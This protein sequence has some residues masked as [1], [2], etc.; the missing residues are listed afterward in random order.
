MGDHWG[1]FLASSPF[2]A[3]HKTFPICWTLAD[4]SHQTVKA[5]APAGMA[6]DRHRFELPPGQIPLGLSDH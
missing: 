6:L 4:I 5:E 2:P 1:D 3:N